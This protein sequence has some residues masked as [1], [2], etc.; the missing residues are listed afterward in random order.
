M[1]ELLDFWDGV[2]MSVHGQDGLQEIK[3]A[4]LCVA[5]DL[6]AARKV[7]GFLGHSARL[8]CSRCKKEFPGGFGESKDYSGF[9]RDKWPPRSNHDHRTMVDLILKEKTITRR[10]Q[11]ES[12]YGCRYSALLDLPYFDPVRMT[13][14]DPMH[15]LFLGSAKHVLKDIWIKGGLIQEKQIQQ[16]QDVMNSMKTP[17]GVGRIPRKIETGFSGFTADQFKNWVTLYSIPCL[18]EILP[19]DDFECWR[20]FVLACRIL[21]QHT[22]TT[23]D[24]ILADAL[25]LHFSKRVQRMYGGTAI[26]P[27]MHMHCHFKDVLLDYGPVYSFWCFS[28]ERYNG[29]LETQPTNNKEVEVQLMQRFISDNNSFAFSQPTIFETEFAPVTI[30]TT[31]SRLTGS[32]LQTIQPSVNHDSLELPKSYRRIIL[33]EHD[34]TAIA[35]VLENLLSQTDIQVNSIAC[36]YSSLSVGGRTYSAIRHNTCIALVTWDTELF[37]DMP[38]DGSVSG[39]NYARPVLINHFVKVSY[40]VDTT[41]REESN[42]HTHMFARV[43]WFCHHPAK[44]YLGQPAEIWC[45]NIFEAFGVHSY[46]PVSSIITHCIHCNMKVNDDNVLVIVPLVL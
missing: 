4:L 37:G 6:P 32:A 39:S 8:G 25:L 15:N 20:H 13:V 16:I 24:V 1:S 18:K 45:N 28:Y 11:L 10:N 2:P 29:I 17:T 9:E 40:C 44:H 14:I 21:C 27:N 33:D 30:H 22:I 7:C 5:S 42:M 19:V 12:Q 41:T 26:T 23:D 3:C 35:K 34:M 31:V 43:S 36:K 38:C 46:I